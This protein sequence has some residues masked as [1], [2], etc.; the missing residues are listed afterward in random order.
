MNARQERGLVIAATK[1][2]RRISPFAWLVPS[3][4]SDKKYH[5]FMDH[6]NKHCSCPDHLELGVRCK[7]IFAVEF[8]IQ[9][10]LFPDGTETTTQTVVVAEK[11]RKTYPQQWV[12]Y[13]AAQTNEKDKFLM[14]LRDLC[15]R[16]ETPA[17]SN[18]NGGRPR[19]PFSDAIF[20]ACF[21]V[22]STFSGR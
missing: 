17:Q 4:N 10:E 3:Q 15:S 16:I 13:N 9:R 14:L 2:I 21:K 18:A 12:A 8:V 20:A 11:V 5:V 6:D 19:I 1:Q 7:H 22:Y